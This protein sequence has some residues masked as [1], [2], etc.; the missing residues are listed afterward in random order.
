[1]Q[2]NYRVSDEVKKMEK[3]IL[4]TLIPNDLKE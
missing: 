3:E 4:D 2:F 1:M